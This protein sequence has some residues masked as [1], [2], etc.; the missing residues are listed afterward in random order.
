ML[1]ILV[2]VDGKVSDIHVLEKLEP[3]LDARAITAVSK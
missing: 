2:G 3:G 1:A